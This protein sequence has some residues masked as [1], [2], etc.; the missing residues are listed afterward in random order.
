MNDVFDVMNIRS[1]KNA[2]RNDPVEWAKKRKVLDTLLRVLE[3]TERMYIVLENARKDKERERNE[4]KREEN[5]ERKKRRKKTRRKME[6]KGRI[7]LFW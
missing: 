2:I 5:R 7:L 4:L 6:K 1:L 3:N